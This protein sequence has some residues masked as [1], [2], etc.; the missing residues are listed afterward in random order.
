MSL[1]ESIYGGI[2]AIVVIPRDAL[3]PEFPAPVPDRPAA[4]AAAWPQETDILD[5]TAAPRPAPPRA[6]PS[7]AGVYVFVYLDA[8]NGHRFW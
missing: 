1:T 3:A 5:A 6:L 7:A 2:R 4:P 8:F